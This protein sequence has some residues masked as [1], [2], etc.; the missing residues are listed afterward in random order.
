LARNL[1]ELRA[2]V[3]QTEQRRREGGSVAKLVH[4]QVALE[5]EIR[6]Y[7]RHQR[8]EPTWQEA[9]PPSFDRE[10]GD[11]LGQAALVEFVHLD[12]T[13]HAVTVVH[14]RPRLRQLGPTAQVRALI[15]RLAFALRRLTRHHADEASRAAA[16]VALRHAAARL[17]AMLL[18]PLADR[19]G[20]RPLLVVPTGPLQSL[21]WSILPSLAGRPL[22]VSPSAGLWRMASRR[23][24]RPGGHVVVADGGLPGARMEAKT[25]AAIY[26]T[27]ALL[28]PL[29]TVGALTDAL[30]R[31][32]LLHLAV[33]GR[34]RADNPLFSSVDLA[35]GPLTVYDLERLER[36]PQTVVLAACESGRTVVL[37]G[38]EL[39]GLSATFLSH[40]TRQLVA[41]VV[42]IPDLETAPLMIAF[43]RLLAAG[44]PAA[45]ALARAQREVPW[46]DWTA[47]AAAAGFVCIGDGFGLPGPPPP[48]AGRD[49][50][51]TRGR[52]GG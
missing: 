42:T 4:R 37:A 34:L 18:R 26:H 1:A 27:T 50:R 40:G 21:P 16:A 45:E 52:P 7:C 46:D 31:A 22:S 43:H 20:E 10:L 38:D 2:T 9:S 19:I 30:H 24:P 3:V 13:L 32:A 15:E 12:E 25:V 33:H 41:S 51:P 28:D 11:E 29:P 36:V 23:P 5:R 44:V 14:G 8:G 48:Q 47:V 49:G 6:D 39:L 17:D 35:D